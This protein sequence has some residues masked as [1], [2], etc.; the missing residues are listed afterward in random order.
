VPI[1]TA[2]RQAREAN[3]PRSRDGR[4]LTAQDSTAQ[5]GKEPRQLTAAMHRIGDGTTT[6]STHWAMAHTTHITPGLAVSSE[7]SS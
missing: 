5:H 7:I 3:I 4:H 1:I 6:T 2:L